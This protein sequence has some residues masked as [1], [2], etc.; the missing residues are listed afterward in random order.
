M[1][2]QSF[3]NF[4]TQSEAVSASL[5][6]ANT[7]SVNLGK[8][9]I[10][11][12]GAA[13]NTSSLTQIQSIIDGIAASGIGAAD[14]L[15]AM[16]YAYLAIGNVEAAKSL[17]SLQKVKGLTKDEIA[18]LLTFASKGFR[19][20]ITNET[21][22][23]GILKNLE[24][25]KK[26]IKDLDPLE[27][28]TRPYQ[29]LSEE[30]TGSV[31]KEIDLL[32]KRKK[33]IDDQ[34][35]K[36]KQITDELKKQND[37]RNKQ[38]KIDKDIVEAKIRG[39]YIQAAILL[40][41]KASNTEEFNKDKQLS[42]LQKRSD[43]L[44]QQI[45]ERQSVSD[46]MVA[47]AQATTNAVTT[48]SQ[49]IVTAIIAQGGFDDK[50]TK[51]GSSLA[52]AMKIPVT[53]KG[54]Q[55]YID[56]NNIGR[57][58]SSG[59]GSTFVPS[60][61]EDIDP[62][63]AFKNRIS[64]GLLEKFVRSQPE[65]IEGLAKL[66]NPEDG[67]RISLRGFDNENYQFIV[68]KNG[69]FARIAQEKASG[70]MIRG[71]GTGT[72]DSI[73]AYLSNGEYVIKADSV[74]K[75]GVGTFDALNTQKFKDGGL[76][77]R[78][79]YGTR[80]G[81][82]KLNIPLSAGSTASMY[83]PATGLASDPGFQL[84]SKEATAFSRQ[85]GDMFNFVTTPVTPSKA[86]SINKQSE[87]SQR[88]REASEQAMNTMHHLYAPSRI[89]TFLM[90]PNIDALLNIGAGDAKWNDYTT[91]AANFLGLGLIKP[92]VSAIASDK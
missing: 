11:L 44:Q 67:I 82:S 76:A 25:F 13:S 3:F 61:P 62:A 72:S 7:N 20:D 2:G 90:Q 54:L 37:Y 74:K 87:Y 18:E 77:S 66:K 29:S 6:N 17:R 73:P 4:K 78:P 55:A 39:D 75:Y 8:S 27:P 16:Y 43:A 71:A 65:I 12:V 5:K 45:D 47:A 19:E 26:T 36:E 49:N 53:K 80:S 30:R 63:K 35:K 88:L 41:E 57:A 70:G 46:A 89:G 21:T 34:I 91:I 68:R 81:S 28:S 15:N 40:Q 42:D 14:A 22:R 23:A 48:G 52:N 50:T 69:D 9:L 24:E 84:D 86:P 51:D 79:K 64:L 1:V 92:G 33:I 58:R 31:K 56:A 60:T 10:Q 59:R 85:L 83:S 32:K 38:L